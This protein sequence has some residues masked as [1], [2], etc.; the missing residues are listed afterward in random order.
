MPKRKLQG[1]VVSD[2]MTKTL[3]VRVEAVKEHKKYK[4]R[5]RVHKNYKAHYTEGSFAVGDSVIIEET[6]PI[7][8]TK[9]WKVAGKI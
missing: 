7:S 4:K 1:T 6:S 8:K 3:V 5:Y 9:S 2:K